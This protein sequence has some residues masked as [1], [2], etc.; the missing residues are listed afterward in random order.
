MRIVTWNCCRGPF[1]KK[2]EALR[3][4]RPDV[5]V[6]TETARPND[7]DTLQRLWFGGDKGSGIVALAFGDYTLEREPAEVPA[8]QDP[9]RAIRVR[10]PVDFHLLAVWG[11][12]GSDYIR[13]VYDRV[14]AQR[15]FAKQSPTVLAGDLNS[16]TIWDRPRA[17]MDHSRF[18]AWLRSELDLVSAYHEHRGEAHG[19]ESKPTYYFL[20]DKAKPYHID[21][22]FLPRVWSPRIRR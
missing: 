4:L 1:E 9:V 12:Q 13:G 5:V 10:G 8:D 20:W 2:S 16:N 3:R 19:K 7:G 18:V 6:L 22:C 21:Y 17:R 14:A 11:R 15:D